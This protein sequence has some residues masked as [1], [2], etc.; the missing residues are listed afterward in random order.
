M[1]KKEK[2]KSGQIVFA[3]EEQCWL[4]GKIITDVRHA[5]RYMGHMIC[6]S[7]CKKEDLDASPHEL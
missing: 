3:I 7:G 4:C 2:P 5:R 6:R 1:E